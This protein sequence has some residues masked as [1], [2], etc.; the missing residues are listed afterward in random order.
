MINSL[1]L[2]PSFLDFWGYYDAEILPVLAPLDH[3]HCYK[4]RIYNAPPVDLG[5]LAQGAYLQYSLKI[6]PGSLIWGFYQGNLS[7]SDPAYA[8]QITDIATGHKLWQSPV[9]NRFVSNGLNLNF[10]SLLCSPYPVVGSGLFEVEFW[11]D[12]TNTG[13]GA[14][15]VRVYLIIG[16]AEVVECLN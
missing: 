6:T 15:L 13:S 10:P 4:P 7:G 3:N 12:V 9:S 2:F 5:V 16:V 14:G 8:V 1:S 11:A